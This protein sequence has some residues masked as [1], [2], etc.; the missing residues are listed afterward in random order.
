MNRIEKAIIFATHAHEGA[1]RK[2]KD[3]AYILHPLEAMIIAAGVTEDEDVLAAAVLHDTIEDTDTTYEDIEREFGKQVADLVGNE[4]ENKREDRPKAETWQIRKQETIDELKHAGRETKIITLG[5]KLSNLREIG[6]DYATVGDVI[7]ERFNQKD[8]K[9]HA[10]YYG[11]LL[12][13]LEKEFG[14]IEAI[15]EYREIMGRVFG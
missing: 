9:M 13:A 3:K 2:G 5:D 11:S 12:K 14:D 4:S 7:W 10:W 8:K 15:R 6:R 1:T